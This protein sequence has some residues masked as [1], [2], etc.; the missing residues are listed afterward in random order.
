MHERSS[1]GQEVALN[2][3]H[4]LGVALP[5]RSG[6][7]IALDPLRRRFLEDLTLACGLVRVA[8]DL[9][10]D[11]ATIELALKGR[12]LRPSVVSRLA[13]IIDEVI[14]GDAST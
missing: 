12:L 7:R 14:D 13:T 5:A 10:S 4:E 2:E 8:V 11:A 1:P 3:A 6:P 9:G